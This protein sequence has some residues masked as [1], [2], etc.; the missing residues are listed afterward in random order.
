MVVTQIEPLTKTKWKV[1]IDGKFAFVLYKGELSRFRIVQGEDVSEEIY[2]KIKNEVIL[3]RVKLRSLHLL[4]QMDRTEEQ[5][6]TKLRQG[7]YTDDMIDTAISYVKSFGYIED[8]AYAKRFVLSRQDSKSRKEIYAKLCQKGIAK[9]V[10]ANAMEEC[11][12][13]GEELTAIKKLVEKK[14]FDPYNATDS[15]RQKIYGYLARK[16]F[17]YDSIRQ[18]IQI[19]DWNA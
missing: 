7:H 17:S 1:Y 6:R 13:D 19:S 10:I 18:V 16:G 5:L 14:R 4:N 8:S 11:Y 9:D 15:E 2:E 3:K 12:E